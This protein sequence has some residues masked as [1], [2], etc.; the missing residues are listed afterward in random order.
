MPTT[1]IVVNFANEIPHGPHE[2]FQRLR[3]RGLRVS[4][5]VQQRRAKAILLPAR[6]IERFGGGLAHPTNRVRFLLAAGYFKARHKFFNRQYHA[7]DI[8]FV[9]AQLG[10]SA[11]DVNVAEHHKETYAR[12]QRLILDY[13]GYGPFDE[14]AKTRI[15]EEIARLVAVQVRPRMV[16]LEAIDVL[17]RKKIEIPTYNLLANLIVAAMDQRQQ[18]LSDIIDSSLTESQREKLDALLAKAPVD[19]EEDGWRYR[20]AEQTGGWHLYATALSGACPS[21]IIPGNHRQKVF[22]KSSFRTWARVCSSRCA[23]R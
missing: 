10:V 17:T 16:L 15:A 22:R 19:G 5:S 1:T 8:G 11:E 4:P 2:D 20:R 12:H 18:A 14:V 3:R 23:P 9:T 21:G 7:A 13:F 6:G